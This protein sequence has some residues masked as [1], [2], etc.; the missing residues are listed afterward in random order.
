M[1]FTC[2]RS[3]LW[4]S[5]PSRRSSAASHSSGLAWT[6]P[7]RP[8]GRNPLGLP[9]SGRSLPKL[10]EHSWRMRPRSGSIRM[11]LSDCVEESSPRNMAKEIRRAGD[12]SK[13]NRARLGRSGRGHEGHERVGAAGSHRATGGR[14]K[15]TRSKR[16][17]KMRAGRPRSLLIQKKSGRFRDRS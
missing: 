2:E 1:H 16:Q 12:F 8:S 3:T 4:A 7:S 11:A 6:S 9:N 14:C 5:R 10:T 13:S 15:T 17:E